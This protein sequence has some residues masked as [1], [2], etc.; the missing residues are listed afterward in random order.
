MK[1]DD[2]AVLRHSVLHSSPGA[3]RRRSLSVDLRPP[4]PEEIQ[5]L[6]KASYKAPPFE[7]TPSRR[8]SFVENQAFLLAETAPR[9]R[10]RSETDATKGENLE[11]FRSARAELFLTKCRE[12][13]TDRISRVRNSKSSVFITNSSCFAIR[14][15][16]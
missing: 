3:R 9:A 15:W 11:K 6:R 7:A 2:D 4:K 14:R 1:Q 13:R 5:L 16:Y 12:E 8:A 10:S